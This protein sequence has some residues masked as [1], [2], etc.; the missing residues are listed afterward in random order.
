MSRKVKDIRIDRRQNIGSDAEA[1]RKVD[2]SNQI[3][4]KANT[5]LVKEGVRRVVKEY[6]EVLRRLA[7]E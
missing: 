5:E 7:D 2:R 6:G 3:V 4:P 1:Y